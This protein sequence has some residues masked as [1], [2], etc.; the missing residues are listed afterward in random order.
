MGFQ[1]T[2][3]DFRVPI[4]GALELERHSAISISLG[5]RAVLIEH[6]SHQGGGLFDK[7]P[8]WLIRPNDPNHECAESFRS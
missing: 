2:L 3:S 1:E 6:L 8:G 4:D 5:S 7:N